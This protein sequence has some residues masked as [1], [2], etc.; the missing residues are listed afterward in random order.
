MLLRAISRD[1]IGLSPVQR[2]SGNV[3]GPRLGRETD[4]CNIG[5]ETQLHLICDPV[6]ITCGSETCFLLLYISLSPERP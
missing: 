6:S 3:K 2:E 5:V 1:H 4:S